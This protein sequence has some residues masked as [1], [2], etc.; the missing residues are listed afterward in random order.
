MDI[1]D[2][3]ELIAD[4]LNITDEQREDEGYLQDMFFDKF[5]IDFDLA[6][7]LAK[8]LLLHVPPIESGLR[9]KYYHAFISKTEPVILMKTEVNKAG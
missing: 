2:F 6:Y 1:F 8:K 7:E 3:E 5:E 9:K 4:M